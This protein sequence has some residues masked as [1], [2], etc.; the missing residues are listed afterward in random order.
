MVTHHTMSMAVL[1]ACL[2]DFAW[3]HLGAGLS[4][5]LSCHLLLQATFGHAA[6]GHA[7]YQTPTMSASADPTT[8]LLSQ[9]GTPPTNF[10]AQQH[11]QL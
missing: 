8:G 2:P 9:S 1:L 5:C 10:N 11:Q 3:Y 4:W 7:L 6:Y